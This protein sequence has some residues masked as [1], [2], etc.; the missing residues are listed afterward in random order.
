MDYEDIAHYTESLENRANIDP[1][2]A[3]Q[4]IEECYAAIEEELTKIHLLSFLEAQLH[5]DNYHKVKEQFLKMGLDYGF[6]S[7]NVRQHLGTNDLTFK[8]RYLKEKGSPGDRHYY[9]PIQKVR[10]NFNRQAFKKYSSHDEELDL[11]M[12]TE[13]HFKRLRKQSNEMKAV[14]RQIKR[15]E[16]RKL[17]RSG[18]KEVNEE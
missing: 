14:M 6:I 15:Q 1:E 10:G 3:R 8:R 4:W 11:A 18:D 5:C 16:T 7:P 2:N 9:Y 13:G 12:M 17:P